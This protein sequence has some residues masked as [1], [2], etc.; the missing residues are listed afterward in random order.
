ML[1]AA[2]AAAVNK[3]ESLRR[4]IFDLRTFQIELD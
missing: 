2:G 4:V 3:F 1:V